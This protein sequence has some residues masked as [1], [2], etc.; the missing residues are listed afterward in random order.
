MNPVRASLSQSPADYEFSSFGQWTKDL[1][2]PF[3]NNIIEHILPLLESDI[4][5]DN[6]R[7][8]RSSQMQIMK[9]S[10]LFQHLLCKGEVQKAKRVEEKLHLQRKENPQATSL[11]SKT[12]WHTSKIIGSEAFIK[13]KWRQWQ[14]DQQ[15]A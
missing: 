11:F 14:Q 2:H 12:D 3:Q 4:T 7:E 6:L 8:H 10:D 5:I 15:Y 13:E 9:T 1:E